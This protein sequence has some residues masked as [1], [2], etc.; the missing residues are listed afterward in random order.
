MARDF[1]GFNSIDR[2]M[3][4]SFLVVFLVFHKLEQDRRFHFFCEK[5][6]SPV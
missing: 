3:G 1:C 2:R 4:Q 5:G 6:L